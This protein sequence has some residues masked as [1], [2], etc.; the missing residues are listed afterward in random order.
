MRGVTK[1][2]SADYSHLVRGLL[3]RI[4]DGAGERP[5]KLKIYDEKA[6]NVNRALTNMKGVHLKFITRKTTF[7]SPELLALHRICSDLAIIAR[8]LCYGIEDVE[9]TKLMTPSNASWESLPFTYIQL[10]HRAAA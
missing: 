2:R 8:S 9:P 7:F 1:K 10:Q 5:G 6:K 4:F 3:A